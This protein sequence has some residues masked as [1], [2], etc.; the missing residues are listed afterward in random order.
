MIEV[1][2]SRGVAALT[3][4]LGIGLVVTLMGIALGFLAFFEGAIG[5]SLSKSQEAYLVAQSGVADAL[6][7]LARDKDFSSA[8]YTVSVGNGS[9]T[10]V[11]T[12]NTPTIGQDLITATGDVQGRKRKL[13][14]KAAVDGTSGQIT[15][16]SWREIKF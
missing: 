8:G 14:V 12:R 16:L 3:T 1:K 9:A 2:E 11:V 4:I 13:E 10:V 6:M 5:F 15:I 7:R